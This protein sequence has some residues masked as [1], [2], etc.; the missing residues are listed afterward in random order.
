LKSSAS[1]EHSVWRRRFRTYVVVGLLLA[2]LGAGWIF[3]RPL[4]TGNVGVVDPGKVFRSAQPFGRLDTLA[5]Q[6]SLA[7]VLNLRGG[8]QDDPWYAEEVRET[9]RLAID[10]FDFPMSATRRPT[11]KELLVLLELLGRCRYPLLIH[12]K[13]G[14]D[15]T[16]LA[17]ALYRT[18]RLGEPPV[19]ALRAFSLEYGHVP[20][21]GPQ[22]LHEPFFEYQSWL[23]DRGLNHTPERFLDWVKHD[24]RDKN[25]TS[26]FEPLRP[27]PRG[28]IAASAVHARQAVR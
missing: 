23:H 21:F 18:F 9:E 19:S 2:A 20:L 16:G 17:T 26:E 6:Y 14:S 25:P 3:W 5:R 28:A 12:C 27:G 13:S 11:R 22:H 8:S 1:G 10:L 4:F 24:Y 15:R 7:S